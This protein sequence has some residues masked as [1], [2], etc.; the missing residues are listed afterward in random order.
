MLAPPAVLPHRSRSSCFFPLL[1][2]AIVA[3]V[4]GCGAGPL[5]Q[6]L[7]GR[8]VGKPDSMAGREKRVPSP[9]TE[10]DEATTSDDNQAVS[11]QENGGQAEE[12]A[13]TNESTDLETFD[14]RLTLDFGPEGMIEMWKEERQEL[15][16]GTWQVLSQTGNR[17]NIEIAVKREADRESEQQPEPILEQR[18]FELVLEPEATGFTL[19]EEGADP[20][21]GWLYFERQ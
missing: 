8:W 4:V 19:R 9:I 13:K 3:N 14:F 11:S 2:V 18:R 20:K 7:V 21:F 1:L 6:Q 16:S 15:L 17:A 5:E 12:P 10:A